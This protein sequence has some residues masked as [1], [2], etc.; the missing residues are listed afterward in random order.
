MTEIQTAVAIAQQF[1]EE[2]FT[3]AKQL[4]LEEVESDAQ[5]EAIWYVTLS[6]L[7]SMKHSSKGLKPSLF[8]TNA[9]K[10]ERSYKI[11]KVDTSNRKFLSMKI[12]EFQH[13]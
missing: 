2:N 9:P 13:G 4:R 8:D 11:I 6:Y 5:N 7:P 3:D 1:I 12:R 10:T